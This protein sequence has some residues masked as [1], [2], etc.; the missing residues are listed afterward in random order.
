MSVTAGTIADLVYLYLEDQNREQYTFA[1]VL[2]EINS[3]WREHLSSI[4]TPYSRRANLPLY[5]DRSIYDFP[6]DI[7]RMTHCY[8]KLFA[9]KK[10]IQEAYVGASEPTSI[11]EVAIY[12]ERVSSNEFELLPALTAS[13]LSRISGATG[14]IETGIVPDS[15]VVGD[16]WVSEDEVIHQCSSA[17]TT[18][19]TSMSLTT[20][21]NIPLE[22]VAVEQNAY[23]DVKITDGGA[24][25]TSALAFSGAGTYSSPYVYSFTLYDNNASNDDVIALLSGDSYLTASGSDATDVDV[26]AYGQTPLTRTSEANW[27]EM[28]LEMHYRAEL[29]DFYSESDTIHPSISNPLRSGEA[30]A[31]LAVAN[32]LGYARANPNVVNA[33]RQ[34]GMAVLS[35]ARY[36]ANKR[37]GPMSFTPGYRL[38]R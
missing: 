4:N 36:Q 3:V 24:S 31:K 2:R 5:E 15:G 18:G 38:R 27:T 17:Y 25:G 26:V 6:S 32:L 1:E 28:Y 20:G 14:T 19:E 21:R 35:E 16:L 10:R 22:F 33:F 30:I 34:E 29:P 13:T 37:M 11:A 8:I 7:I 23:I 12:R 9:E